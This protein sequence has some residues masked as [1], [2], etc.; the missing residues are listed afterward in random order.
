MRKNVVICTNMQFNYFSSKGTSYLGEH[1]KAVKLRVSQTLKE[2][3]FDKFEVFHTRDVRSP[4]DK[5]YAHTKTQC[6]VGTLDINMVDGLAGAN[7]LVIA[8]TR[9]SALWKTPLL[10]EI[11]K[12]DPEEIYLIGAETN[13]AVLFTAADLRF[14]GYTVKVPE[15]LVV[16]RDEYLHN[17]AITLMAD[18]LG[19]EVVIGLC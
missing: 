8:S 12:N 5:F 6:T 14:L 18:T 1:S 3:D 7:S 13:S 16:A 9:P 15:P 2:L 10:S 4:E 19:V 11:K 17:F